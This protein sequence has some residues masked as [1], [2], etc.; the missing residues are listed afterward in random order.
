MASRLTPPSWTTNH[1]VYAVPGY[2]NL[3]LLDDRSA[4]DQP[5]VF[6]DPAANKQ[7]DVVVDPSKLS[8]VWTS[9][10]RSTTS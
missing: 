4:Y 2:G 9:T 1:P 3:A 10:S 7:V 8:R 6:I 5:S